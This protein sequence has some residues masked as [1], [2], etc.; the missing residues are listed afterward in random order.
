MTC[1]PTIT[2]V[3]A[4]LATVK[5][6]IDN[7][8]AT[9]V[10]EIKPKNRRIMGAGGPEEEEQKWPP[11]L[12]PMLRE[13]FFVQCKLHKSEC[14]MIDQMLFMTMESQAEALNQLTTD[15]LEGKFAMLESTSVSDHLASLKKELSG[16]TKKG[17]LPPGRTSFSSQTASPS[18]A[19]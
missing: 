12:K 14:N 11:W 2:T 13:S 19:E 10:R 9:I 15:D 8:V 7:Q 3:A 4:A 16:T 6:A 17:E 1:H 5:L 18:P